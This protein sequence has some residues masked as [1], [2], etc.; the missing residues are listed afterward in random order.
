MSISSALFNAISGLNVASRAA[1]VV[2]SNIANAMTDGYGVREV[3]IAARVIGTTGAGA[4][5]V[6]ITRHEDAALSGAR[7][8]AEA[9][10]AGKEVETGFLTRLEAKIGTPD[11]T[12]SL[13]ARLAAF[14]AR[15]IDAANAP[16]QTVHLTAAIEAALD[17]SDRINGVQDHIQD[18]RLAADHDIAAAV[19]TLNANLQELGDLNTRI[20]KGSGGGRDISALQ[21][22]QAQLLEGISGLVPVHTRRDDLGALQVFTDDGFALLDGVAAEF[23]F[24]ASTV[25]TPGLTRDTGLSGLTVNGRATETEGPAATVSGGRL[26]ALF[27]LRDR[28][29]VAAQTDL[30]TVA[31]DL[32]QRFEDIGPDPTR[33]PGD[34]GL[35]TD[36][37]AAFNAAALS[38]LAGRL[39]VN[40]ALR[41]D[42]GGHAW[43]LRDGLG[44]ALPGPPGQAALLTAQLDGLSQPRAV[45]TGAAAGQTLGAAALIADQITTI[46]VAKHGAA[47]ELSHIAAQHG[48]LV[49][50]EKAQGV[51]TDAEMQ[52]LL[53]IEQSYAA[54]AQVIA[55]VQDMMDILMRIGR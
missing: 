19:T 46:G 31:A 35:F 48:A 36:N 52:R 24:T 49:T 29:G 15:L 43:R 54:N 45:A 18:A 41:S 39:Q 51:D 5:V 17:L 42:A 21:D 28:W 9:A 27:D 8:L 6:G 30:D 34:P 37:G 25:M 16:T 1:G 44:A 50:E 32:V 38:G 12:G 13:T 33:A 23:G 2:S 11:Q 7:R 26:A 3:Q 10:R 55:A 40:A 22:A 20:R 47:T 53:R 14:E 4:R